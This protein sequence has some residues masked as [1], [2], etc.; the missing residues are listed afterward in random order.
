MLL[1][2]LS[3]D[4]HARMNKLAATQ[5]RG[6]VE[7]YGRPG[8]SRLPW[9]S[10]FGKAVA[11]IPGQPGTETLNHPYVDEK[12]LKSDTCLTC[13]PT[14]N[15][16]KHVHAA[17]GM[18]CEGCHQAISRDGQT[19]I[20]L[21][22]TGG[23]L[24]AKCHAINNNRVQHAPYA[25]GQCLICHNPHSGAYPAET[26]AAVSTLCLVCHM[27]N[28]PGASLSADGKRVSLLDGITYDR[29]EW[30]RA[31]KINSRH[32]ERTVAGSDGSKAEAKDSGKVNDEID[33]LACHQPHAG[34]AEHL[35]R[36]HEGT[37]GATV[38]PS[39]AGQRGFRSTESG[40]WGVPEHQGSFFRG[41]A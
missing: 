34:K 39:G 5:G 28:Q 13:H 26:R 14:K 24:C 21:L 19:M 36:S 15:Q 37:G 7:A 32:G 4:G 18:G 2:V 11:A 20:T 41:H 30:Q 6:P 33:C 12:E 8:V 35:L 38:W 25:Q 16:G 31:P 29:V 27:P 17:V 23:S 40:L 3:A 9:V 1:L 22:A 10:G